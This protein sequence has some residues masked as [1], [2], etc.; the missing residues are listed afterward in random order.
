[1]LCVRM[2]QESREWLEATA[3]KLPRGRGRPRGRPADVIRALILKAR[4]EEQQR[5]LEE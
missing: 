5:Y 2:D 4:V 3:R 1:M